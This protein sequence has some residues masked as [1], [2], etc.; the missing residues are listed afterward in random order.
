M[1]ESYSRWQIICL[2][3]KTGREVSAT[4]R[5]RN[6]YV[7]FASVS[8]ATKT[9]LPGTSINSTQTPR[10]RGTKF[11]FESGSFDSAFDYGR[12]LENEA[13]LSGLCKQLLKKIVDEWH[14]LA[15]FPERSFVKESPSLFGANIR[16]RWATSKATQI[17]GSSCAKAAWCDR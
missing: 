14:I 6:F 12:P 15:E 8:L 11:Q 3:G 17:I 16:E 7:L 4:A 1:K 2:N 10:K 13:G 9:S 5:R